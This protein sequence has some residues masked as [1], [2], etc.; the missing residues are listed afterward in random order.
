MVKQT[1]HNVAGEIDKLDENETLAVIN[2]ISQL[3]ST[4]IS[5][6]QENFINDDLIV[7][8]ADAYEN[9]RARQVFEWEKVRR[10]NVQRAA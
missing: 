5:K 8:L 3:L 1:K 10:Q 7:S 9:K 2:C 6:Q 4:R